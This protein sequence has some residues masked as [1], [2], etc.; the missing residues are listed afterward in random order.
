[1]ANFPTFPTS[2]KNASIEVS[3]TDGTQ[4]SLESMTQQSSYTY[5]GEDYTNRVYLLGTGKTLMNVRPAK[6]PEINVD[7]IISGLELSTAAA[8]DDIAVSAGSIEVDGTTYT[9]AADAA[10]AISVAGEGQYAWNAITVVKST[11][12]LA[13]VKGTDGTGG[14]KT[15]C[16]DTYGDAAGQRPLIP[17]GNLLI[18]WTIVGPTTYTVLA[19][20]I[21]Y[22]DREFGGV[23]YQLLPNVGGVL[24]Q[25]ALQEVHSATIGGTPS[26]RTVKFSGYYLDDVMAKIGTAKSFSM[27]PSTTEV[28]DDTF[29]GGYAQTEI[30]AWSGSFEQLLAD[31]KVMNAA[32]KRQGHCALRFILPNGYGWQGVAT[33]AP[34]INAAVGSMNNMSVAASF[35]DAPEEYTG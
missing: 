5:R 4:L 8:V 11:Q 15:D 28:S 31:P 21:D 13:V 32:T 10:L 19:T 23:D 22:Q 18:G 33:V 35:G 1:M 25:S 3:F 24:L 27:T 30:G 34:T 14:L 26:A 20:D 2:G 12:A 16:L 6:E 7:G 17:I 9:V 29:A